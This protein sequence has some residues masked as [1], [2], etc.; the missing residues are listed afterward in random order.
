MEKGKLIISLDFESMWGVSADFLYDDYSN[1]IVGIDASV[2]GT[3]KLFEKY[4]V[5]ASWAVVGMMLADD[6]QDLITYMPEETKRPGYTNSVADNYSYIKKRQSKL[7]D[8]H[9]FLIALVKEIQKKDNQEISSHTFSHYYTMEP[10]Q[11]LETFIQ[12]IECAQL[13]ARSKLNIQHETIV[14]PKNQC[15]KTY[16]DALSELGIKAYRGE[17][18]DWIHKIRYV[19]L[20]RILRLVDSYIPLTGQGG[21]RLQKTAGILNIKGSRFFRPY[22]HTLRAFERLKLRRIKRQMYHAAKHGLIFHLWW[23]PHNFGNLT[24]IHMRYLD[25]ILTCYKHLSEKYGMESSNMREC[26]DRL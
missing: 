24:E 15:E 21:Y 26:L 4:D 20:K 13:I 16:I 6:Y 10:G 23:H 17:E 14:L 25:E 12:D 2:K 22:N 5:H 7:E 1:H 8:E 11:T 3:L 19:P 9:H 18:E